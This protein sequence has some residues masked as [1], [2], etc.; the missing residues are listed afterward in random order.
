MP[1]DEI[2]QLISNGAI[3]HSLVIVAFYR[4]FLEY[5]KGEGR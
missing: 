2:T 3:I 4:Y 5:L 1:L